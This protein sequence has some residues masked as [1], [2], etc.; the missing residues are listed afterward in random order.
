[1]K[2]IIELSNSN[3]T[4]FLNIIGVCSVSFLIGTVFGIYYLKTEI[5]KRG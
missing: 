2:E 1:M 3:P 4:M 5:L